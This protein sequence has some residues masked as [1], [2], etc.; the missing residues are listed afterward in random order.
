MLID[1]VRHILGIVL[2]VSTP[3]A[4]AYWLVI[5][6]F[7]RRWR[8][9]DIRVTYAILAVFMVGMGALL[10]AARAVLMGRDLGTSWPL[11]GVGGVLYLMAVAVSLE[12]RKQLS[13]RTF[14]GVPELSQAAFPGQMLQEGIYGVIRHPRYLSVI[15]GTVGMGLAVNFAGAYL[16]L[17]V[18]LLG[19][20]PLIRMEERE[21]VSRFGSAYVAYRSRVPALI[22]RFRRP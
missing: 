20:W 3:P 15:L 16:L 5:H 22:P 11:I 14:A 12:A 21:L 2:V 6:P 10:F 13:T 7:A 1:T 19:L 17:V 8:Q 9:L 18:S 4:I